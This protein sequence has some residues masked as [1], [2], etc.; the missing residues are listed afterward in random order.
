MLILDGVPN[1]DGLIRIGFGV[2][3]AVMVWVVT[4]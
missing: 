2:P 1:T 3:L 4:T